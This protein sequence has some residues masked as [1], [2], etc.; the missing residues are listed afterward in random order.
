[1]RPFW[2]L[3]HLLVHL[4]WRHWH[5]QWLEIMQNLCMTKNVC[6]VLKHHWCLWCLR[7]M[8]CTTK[9][10]FTVSSCVWHVYHIEMCRWCNVIVVLTCTNNY[11][12]N[13]AILQFS[14]PS[15]N[16]GNITFNL[17]NILSKSIQFFFE[18][19]ICVVRSKDFSCWSWGKWAS[20]MAS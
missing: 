12:Y 8:Q 13:L 14:H 10:L 18:E 7:I 3:L 11:Y 4:W 20:G 17:G 19:I 15:F 9:N 6:T 16:L 2:S 1:M 5:L